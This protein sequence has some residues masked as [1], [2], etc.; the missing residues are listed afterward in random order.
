M[1]V[2]EKRLYSIASTLT[3]TENERASSMVEMIREETDG[4]IFLKLKLKPLITGFHVSCYYLMMF[5]L[6]ILLSFILVHMT[7][8]LIEQYDVD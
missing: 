6:T 1:Q 8:I 2:N 4:R 3:A 7:F 5:T